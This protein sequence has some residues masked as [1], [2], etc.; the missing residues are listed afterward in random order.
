MEY[1]TGKAARIGRPAAGKTG[2]ADNYTNAW[3]VGFTPEIAVSVWIGNDRQSEPMQYGTTVIG[4]SMS[5]RIFQVFAKEYLKDYPVVHFT[6]P[7]N[8]Q[9]VSIDVYTGKQSS[10]DKVL[11]RYYAFTK[12]NLPAK[13]R[14][15]FI[16]EVTE[17][18][19]QFWQRFFG[20]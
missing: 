2:I 14:V 11:L 18:L 5:A 19:Q 12:D 1:G 16:N 17:K 6:M 20:F 9:R 13:D 3:F 8:V 15:G 10:S 7:E 4:S